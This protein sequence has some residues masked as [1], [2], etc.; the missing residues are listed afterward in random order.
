M[1]P[2][3]LRSSPTR[4]YSWPGSSS[5]SLRPPERHLEV[6]IY[7]AARSCRD[8]C[9]GGNQAGLTRE[10]A[11]WHHPIGD[12]LEATPASARSYL[13]ITYLPRL[14][15]WHCEQTVLVGDAAHAMT[16][17]LGQGAAQALQD[18]ASL[19]YH[20]KAQ[21]ALDTAL[22][23]YIE[24]RKRS[25]ERVAARSNTAGQIAQASNPLVAKL[26]DVFASRLPESIVAHQFAAILNG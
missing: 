9:Q 16:P 12:L 25:A 14:P 4:R 7:R 23:S 10:F 8:P 3:A 17:N 5:R 11:D 21:P 2:S 19:I 1:I 18:V 13:P 22:A 20:L 15:R 26:R 24:E 6:G